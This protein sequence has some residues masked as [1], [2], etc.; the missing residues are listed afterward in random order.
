MQ[1]L[2]YTNCDV[3]VLIS[4]RKMFAVM[5]Y[6]RENRN[7]NKSVQLSLN[8][9]RLPTKTYQCYLTYFFI[10]IVL[11]QCAV[12]VRHWWRQT[13]RG[14][15]YFTYHSIEI[16]IQWYSWSYFRSTQEYYLRQLQIPIA[17]DIEEKYIKK[18]TTTK[19]NKRRDYR[20]KE[21]PKNVGMPTNRMSYFQ[22]Q[23]NWKHFC[24]EYFKWNLSNK[25]TF[26]TSISDP[27]ITCT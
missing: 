11:R 23:Q 15:F 1:G 2:S 26:E 6:F 22:Q 16:F 13:E 17:G 9:K 21:Q 8:F 3:F 10:F 4:W 25:T 14:T 18:T 20:T 24:Y 12:S 7:T 27:D 5:L 19:E